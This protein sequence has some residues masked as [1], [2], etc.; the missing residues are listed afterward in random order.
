VLADGPA[1]TIGLVTVGIYVAALV[2]LLILTRGRL[3]RAAAQR[4]AVGAT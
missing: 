4:R 1:N 2:A 3:G